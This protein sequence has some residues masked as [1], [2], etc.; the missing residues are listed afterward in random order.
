MG[1]DFVARIE[2][3]EIRVEHGGPVAPIP[4]SASL[5]AGLRIQYQDVHARDKRGHDGN[6]RL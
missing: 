2:H 1:S 6:N 5:H 3:S 4:Q